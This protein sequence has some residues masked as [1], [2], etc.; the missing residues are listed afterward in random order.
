MLASN[1]HE[2]KR[3]TFKK[4]IPNKICFGGITGYT[5]ITFDIEYLEKIVFNFKWWSN[6]YRRTTGR[7]F[8]CVCLL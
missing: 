1:A 6:I 2:N 3:R 4:F 8:F 5:Q 7:D